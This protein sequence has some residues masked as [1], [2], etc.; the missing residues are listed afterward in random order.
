MPGECPV[1]GSVPSTCLTKEDEKLTMPTHSKKTLLIQKDKESIPS[2]KRFHEKTELPLYF[3]FISVP[4]WNVGLATHA[5][6]PEFLPT[7][8]L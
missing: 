8:C 1:D 6:G 5:S 3:L 2:P 4:V 7:Q